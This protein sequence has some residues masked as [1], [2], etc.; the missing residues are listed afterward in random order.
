MKEKISL[1][2]EEENQITNAKQTAHF[3]IL[4]W[5]MQST[6]HITSSQSSGIYVP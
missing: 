4:V 5:K 1:Q 2:T 3:F 6:D